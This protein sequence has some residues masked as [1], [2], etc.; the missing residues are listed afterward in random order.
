V[1]SRLAGGR[2]AVVARCA[3]SCDHARVIEHGRAPPIH[4]VA[5]VAHIVRWHVRRRLAGRLDTVVTAE[6]CAEHVGVVDLSHRLE[7]NN[8]MAVFADVVGRDVRVRLAERGDV[9]VAADAIAGHVRMIE[10]SGFPCE[11]RVARIT[12]ECRLDV[13][14]RLAGGPGTI[15][16]A[17]AAAEHVRVVDDHDR[18]ERD[19][20]MTCLADVVREH[21][22]R[23][24]A[25]RI[26][27]V[28]ALHAVAHDVCV[29][30]R[31]GFPRK[32]GVTRTAVEQRR[33]VALRLAGRGGP[34]VALCT[35]ALH[36]HVINGDDRL[37]RNGRMAAFT[38]VIGAYVRRR[39]ADRIDVV[40]A[41]EAIAGDVDVIERRGLPRQR[42]VT[43]RAIDRRRNVARRLAGCQGAVVATSAAAEH[44]VVIDHGDRLPR[45]GA[46]AV[47]AY[48]VGPYVRGGLARDPHVVMARRTTADDPVVAERRR[49]PRHGAVAGIALGR[50]R[51][52]I[53]ILALCARAVVARRTAALHVT[54]IDHHDRFKRHRRMARLAHHVGRNVRRVFAGR[55]HA[56]VALRTAVNNA[57]VVEQRGLPCQ[58]RVTLIAFQRRL[59]VVLGLAGRDRAL[60]AARAIAQHVR[61]INPRDRLPEVRRVA[62]FADVV[63]KDV[64]GAFAGGLCTVMAAE[65]AVDDARVVK[66]HTGPRK[67]VV[68]RG[69]IVGRLR[70]GRRFRIRIR[71]VVARLTRTHHLL[72]I[73]ERHRLPTGRRRMT[74]LTHRRRQHVPRR[75]RRVRDPIA[76]VVASRAGARRSFEHASYVARFAVDVAVHAVE[77]EAGRE[78]IERRGYRGGMSERRD[79]EHQQQDE[80]SSAAFHVQITCS[81]IPDQ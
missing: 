11:R 80:E 36:V 7:C 78:V 25:D 20:R 74:R 24:F 44:V 37:E 42:R 12:F 51:E 46:V 72:V 40:V 73:D 55:A 49:L 79:R 45:D 69:A 32:R 38:D 81:A 19:N 2:L 1:I 16:A 75:L 57:G 26:D 6:A 14:A 70:M 30:E 23:R 28:V 4:R 47:L 8:R 13:T 76:A 21:V 10:A 3:R 71:A 29:I 15:V 27:V 34:V 53:G 48:I 77:F 35:V 17:A 67:G 52:M 31:R 54:V 41:L 65:T 64:S 33:N 59:H 18:F 62:V 58:R 68:A 39:F 9:V 63:R 60:V 5:V 61:V 66:R 43:R 50:C 22:R 56:V